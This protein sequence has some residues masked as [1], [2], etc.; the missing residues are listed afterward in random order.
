MVV[1]KTT[2]KYFYNT[3]NTLFLA[4]EQAPNIPAF[5]PSFDIFNLVS[6]F[7]KLKEYLLIALLVGRRK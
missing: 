3:D 6:V 5:S 4:K 2:I 1:I 7:T